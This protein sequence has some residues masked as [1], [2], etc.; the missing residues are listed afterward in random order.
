M[1]EQRDPKGLY[2]AARA[3]KIKQFTGIDDPCEPALVCTC[4]LPAALP[5]RPNRAVPWPPPLLNR[6]ARLAL[7]SRPRPLPPDEEPTAAEIVL[8]ARDASGALCSAEEMAAAILAELETR[9]VLTPPSPAGASVRQ[10]AAAAAA[11][12]EGDA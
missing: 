3:G 10:A 1:C 5:A 6:A 2:K 12:A 8:D 7:A 11:G 4:C 9:G